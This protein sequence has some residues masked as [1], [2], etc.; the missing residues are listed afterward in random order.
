VEINDEE[1]VFEDADVYEE[2]TCKSSLRRSMSWGGAEG[3][4]S[5]Q[6]A[7]IYYCQPSNETLK[8][9]ILYHLRILL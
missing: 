2:V 5:V 9:Y 1:G 4:A 6:I 3:S 8:K 7:V